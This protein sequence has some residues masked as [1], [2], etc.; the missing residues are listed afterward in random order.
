M[1]THEMKPSSENKT[2]PPVGFN[3][4]CDYILLDTS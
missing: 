2:A 3:D 4:H 1:M